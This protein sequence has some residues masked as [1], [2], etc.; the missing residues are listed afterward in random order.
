M[1]NKNSEISTSKE[2]YIAA[3]YRLQ[4]KRGGPVKTGELSE[5]MGV[6]KPSVSE[7]CRRL[8]SDRLVAFKSYGGA[9]LT[10]KGILNARKVIRKHRIL[11]CFFSQALRI[12]GKRVH[13]EAHTIEHF[14]SDDVSERINKMIGKPG[15]CPHGQCIP[16]VKASR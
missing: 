7:M 15:S 4:A 2:D 9:A 16:G 11:E 1:N 3:I 13:D 5:V 10:R 12:G 6:S 8:E 14:I